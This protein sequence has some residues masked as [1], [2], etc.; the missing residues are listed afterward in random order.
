M[1]NYFSIGT[2]GQKRKLTES[3]LIEHDFDTDLARGSS[4][5]DNNSSSESGS[6][7]S[8]ENLE[9]DNSRLTGILNRMNQTDVGTRNSDRLDPIRSVRNSD[10]ESLLFNR[11]RIARAT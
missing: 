6:N 10:F 11:S 5:I 2:I 8:N 1:G 4:T 9:D 3:D 7:Q